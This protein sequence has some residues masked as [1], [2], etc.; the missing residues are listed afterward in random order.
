VIKK[1]RTQL[2]LDA[3]RRRAERK[4][5][6]PDADAALALLR[7]MQAYSLAIQTEERLRKI[8]RDERKGYTDEQLDAVLVHNLRRIA[9]RLNERA[10]WEF[11]A[12]M[13]G[14]KVADVLQPGVRVREAA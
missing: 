12:I 8:T 14:D 13:Y 5:W 3:K 1:Y 10:R 4:D 9:T 2:T 11:A 6:T 7:V